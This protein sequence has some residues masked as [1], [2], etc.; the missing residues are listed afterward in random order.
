VPRVN[1]W[2]RA[3][4]LKITGRKYVHTITNPITLD[5]DIMRTVFQGLNTGN[6]TLYGLHPNTQKDIY[7]DSPGLVVSAENPD[8]KIELAVWYES[9]PSPVT[10]FKGSIQKAYTHRSGAEVVTEIEALDGM[11]AVSKA[12]MQ[13][14]LPGGW[15]AK[16]LLDAMSTSMS[17]EGVKPAVISGRFN[18]T[19]SRS[20]PLSGNTWAEFRKHLGPDSQVYID[21]ER[22]YVLKEDEAFDVP[23]NI[24][25]IDS[26][27]GLLETP[28]KSYT[29][30]DF[31]MLL[32]P[33][34]FPGQ[35]VRVDSTLV[36]DD[37]FPDKVVVQHIHHAGTISG[38]SNS[39]A[40]TTLK[41]GIPL[42]GGPV[43]VG[44]R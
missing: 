26:S 42:L 13:H 2:L 29:T 10:I 21:M 1:K 19:G 43:L 17:G 7:K 23:G 14:V 40:T 5:F 34:I 35:V 27:V 9:L 8:L 3:Y 16:T 33:R 30:V 37:V 4:E 24:P 11:L 18:M 28:R 31:K 6:F 36:Q 20:L 32:E 38:A 39:P 15:N 25:I 41:T 22:L 44:L 12:T